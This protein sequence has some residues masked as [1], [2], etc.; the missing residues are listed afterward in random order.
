MTLKLVQEADCPHCKKKIELETDV[1]QLSVDKK[2]IGSKGKATTEEEKPEPE[3]KEVI[4]EVTKIPSHIPS[5]KCKDGS[6]GRMHN[7]P[8]Y[9][10]TIKGKCSNC[11]QFTADLD[12][13]C[14]FCNQKEYDELEEDELKDLGIPEPKEETHDH[15]GL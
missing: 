15:E 1:D 9:T 10:K 8:N 13:E 14:P 6:C 3:V 7:N 5:Y 4:K 11:G 12:S 2:Q